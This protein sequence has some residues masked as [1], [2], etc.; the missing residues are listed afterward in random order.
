M[1]V[2]LDPGLIRDLIE[3]KAAVARHGIVLIRSIENDLAPAI[4]S[5][6]R[7]SM[8][9]PPRKLSQMTEGELDKYLLRLRKKAMRTSDDLA[10]LYKRLLSRLG[11]DKKIDF[12]K[13][14]GGM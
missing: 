4:V 8:A 11:T 13:G 7:D 12:H 5:E 14:R 1:A 3:A 2:S 6:A 9:T 10:E